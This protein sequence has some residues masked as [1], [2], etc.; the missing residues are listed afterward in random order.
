MPIDRFKTWLKDGDMKQPARTGYDSG[1]SVLDA[2]E[3]YGNQQL[4]HSER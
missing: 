3:R 2:L 4:S 1:G